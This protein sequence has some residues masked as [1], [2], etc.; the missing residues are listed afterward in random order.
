LDDTGYF[1][2]LDS[3]VET[4]IEN[5][6]SAISNSDNEIIFKIDNKFY[7]L[8]NAGEL[9]F[10]FQL[11]NAIMLFLSSNNHLIFS[12]KKEIRVWDI[13]NN[14]YVSKGETNFNI[15]YKGYLTA[16]IFNQDDS[17][18]IYTVYTVTNKIVVYDVLT[19]KETGKIK[20]SD[21]GDVKKLLL[22]NDD[23]KLLVSNE[24]GDILIIQM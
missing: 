3:Q 11:K 22:F 16:A 12:I 2:N 6:S 9:T 17:K 7:Q 1:Y 20:L 21:F 15:P 14:T 23:E 4:K 10:L 13:V 8:N 24:N 19:Y 18:L 5:V